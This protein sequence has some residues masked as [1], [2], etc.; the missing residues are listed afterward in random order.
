MPAWAMKGMPKGLGLACAAGMTSGIV[1]LS[2]ISGGKLGFLLAYLAALPL[3]L[4]GLAF[5]TA[6]VSAAIV[7]GT[8][9]VAAAGFAAVPAFWVLAGAPALVLSAAALRRKNGPDGAAIWPGAGEIVLALAA[10][11]VV[12]MGL[13]CLAIPSEAGKTIE[14]TL[15]DQA[16]PMFRAVWP[17]ATPDLQAAI[18]AMSVAVMPSIVGAAW[19][20]MTLLNGLAAG[21]AVRHAGKA[22]R[23]MP[24]AAGLTVP[25]W[26]AVLAGLAFTGRLLGGNLGYLAQNAAILLMLPFM[27]AGLTDVHRM[28]RATN[29]AGL[30]LGLFY[31]VFIAL[32]GWAAMAV[33]AWGLV[34]QCIRLRRAQP[35]QDQED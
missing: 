29:L 26:L 11:A 34:R 14:A 13:V 1:V 18:V 2:V 3:M 21:W 35:A 10:G 15:G 9:V 27:V 23:P 32:F 12:I 6:S 19:F 22:Q 20:M 31:G 25:L 17:E 7:V 5:G 28:L 16:A 33:T 30:W 24:D 8:A 4:V